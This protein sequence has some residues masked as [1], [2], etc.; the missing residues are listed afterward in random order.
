MNRTLG[1][2]EASR[3]ALQGSL[4]SYESIKSQEGERRTALMRDI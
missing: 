2:I 4:S 1:T 3:N